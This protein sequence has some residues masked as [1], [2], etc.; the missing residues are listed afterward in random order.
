MMTF[1][2]VM[3]VLYLLIG[4]LLSFKQEDVEIHNDS[5]KGS[6]YEQ[7]HRRENK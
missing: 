2:I 1:I 4:V 6:Y 3:C 7:C 5:R